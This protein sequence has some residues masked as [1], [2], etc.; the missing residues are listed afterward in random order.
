MVFQGVL[1]NTYVN[2]P[3]TPDPGVGLIVPYE[4][5]RV[6]VYIRNDQ[7][8]FLDW[9][10][11]IEIGSGALLRISLAVNRKWPLRLNK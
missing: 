3:R 6:V 9:L 8:A 2:Y 10:R 1:D 5:K 4:A 11:W 7:R